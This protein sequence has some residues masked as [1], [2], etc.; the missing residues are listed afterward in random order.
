MSEFQSGKCF[1]CRGWKK[2]ASADSCSPAQMYHP[3][4]SAAGRCRRPLIGC[5][6]RRTFSAIPTFC[7]DGA[8]TNT[9]PY[10]SHNARWII[11]SSVMVNLE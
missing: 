2:S 8:G 5:R 11:E 10:L 6:P 3:V 1:T 9:A 4:V 7:D